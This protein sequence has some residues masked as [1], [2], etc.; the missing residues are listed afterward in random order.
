MYRSKVLV[1]AVALMLLFVAMLPAEEEKVG[2]VGSDVLDF[3][4][5]T[6]DGKT[7]NTADLKGKVTMLMFWFPT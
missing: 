2:E 1:V 5:K 3:T 7:I 4:L 6:Y